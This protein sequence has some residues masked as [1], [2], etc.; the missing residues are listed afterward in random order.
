MEPIW[1]IFLGLRRCRSP[2]V[3]PTAMFEDALRDLTYRDIVLDPF[4]GSGSI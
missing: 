2:T 4:L 3:K 1:R